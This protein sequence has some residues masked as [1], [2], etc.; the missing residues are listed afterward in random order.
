[1]E[2]NMPLTGIRKPGY[3]CG[4]DCPAI[5]TLNNRIPLTQQYGG[6]SCWPG[7]GELDIFECLDSGNTRLKATFH[8]NN[9]GGDSDYF[10]R[11]TDGTM[12]GAVIFDSQANTAHILVLDDNVDFGTSISSD[13]VNDW[14]SSRQDDSKTFANFKLVAPGG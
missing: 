4:P 1:M 5:W 9:S 7:C 8:G 13:T 11:P 2:F 10:E 14:V 6:C 12:K 3:Q